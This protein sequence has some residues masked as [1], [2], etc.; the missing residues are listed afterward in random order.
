MPRSS[1][2]RFSLSS[3]A[4]RF[5]VTG[6][7]FLGIFLI[8]VAF[9]VNTLVAEQLDRA[10]QERMR[11][12]V[13][14][15]I[16]ATEVNDTGQ[17]TIIPERLPDSQLR[18]SSNALYGV[19]RDRASRPVWHSRKIAEPHSQAD[20]PQAG[21][22]IFDNDPKRGV[23]R[24]SLGV[25]WV[26]QGGNAHYLTFSISEINAA[27]VATL[28]DFRRNL[29]T[30]LIAM[31]VILLALL[32]W[33]LNWALSPLRRLSHDM[34]TLQS[35]KSERV[36]GHYPDEV[37]PL[38]RNL[39]ALLDHERARQQRYRNA[40]GDLAH[41]LKTPLAVLRSNSSDAAVV[42]EQLNRMNVI[43]GRQLQRAATRG[44]GDTLRT[45]CTPYPIVE[46]LNNALLKLYPSVR[47]TLNLPVDARTPLDGADALEV[48]G[49]LLENACKYGAKHVL[50][51]ADVS[52]DHNV[53]HTIYIEDDGPGFSADLKD[54]TTRGIRADQATEGQGIGLA[55]VKDIV[56][57]YGAHFSLGQSTL[58]GAK[59]AI[60][61]RS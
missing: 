51:R 49:N 58:G 47:F 31:A 21:E 9:G 53:A 34:Q 11:G 50:V 57:S 20:R 33:A 8:A 10:Q 55:M 46:R 32:L 61:M 42:N 56:D 27:V 29:A 14:G 17:I 16:G 48:L 59:I 23:Y 41:S 37:E 40:L 28:H 15:L 24:L 35:G 5:I 6:V 12:M 44:G 43:V 18:R 52:P 4:T 3:L 39:N 7:I 45:W 2:R 22:W 1:R 60:A 26:S 13:F 19:I 38:V 25:Q 30:W 54:L 36:A